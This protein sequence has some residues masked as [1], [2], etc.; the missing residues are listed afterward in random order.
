MS[1]EKSIKRNFLYNTAYQVF[2]MI[3]PFITA[4]YTA[5]VLEADGVGLQSYISSVTSYFTIIAMLGTVTYGQR[6]IARNR[7]DKRGQSRVFW[8]IA[9]VRL[10]A[11][12]I[13]MIPWACLIFTSEQYGVYYVASTITLVA[14]FF[15]ISWFYAGIENFKMVVVRNFFV[16]IAAIVSL[17]LF[18]KDKN[19]VLIY[20]IVL[21]VSTL[22][23]NMSMWVDLHK[24]I[25]WTKITKKGIA[26]HFKETLVY[27]IPT[28]AIS[29]YTVLD[30]AMLGCLTQETYENGYYEQ[31]SKLVNMAKAIVLS[32][33]TVMFTRMS[34]LFKVD[35]EDEI[36]D[37]LHKSIDVI[38]GMSLPMV[39]GLMAIS[40]TFVPWF[41]GAGYDKV[42]TLIYLY[43][44]LVLVIGLSNCLEQQYLTPAG[45]I[46]KSNKVII[47]GAIVNF[48]LNLILIPQYG[49]YG[50]TIAS[51]IAEVLILVLFIK[52]STNQLNFL[53]IFKILVRRFF[54]VVI[55]YVVVY[56]L[57]GVV[58]S[59]FL[60]LV[61]Q[62]LVGIGVYVLLLCIT[63]DSM[64][65]MVKNIV[66]NKMRSKH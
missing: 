3:T 51:V 49:A 36:K 7:D 5:R 38:I 37:K 2:T 54:I 15:D 29:V 18:V 19:D 55:M 59:P 57:N 33:N 50:A 43:M 14:V 31:A 53:N 30:K 12:M 63:K 27:F 8:E 6:E 61:I 1:R 62:V 9:I 17:F 10:I 52:M 47:L 60:N 41:L 56:S 45:F 34:Y 66:F 35:K 25:A 42:V 20:I 32:L 26:Y 65:E 44:P 58:N 16:K 24:Y 48:F 46:R 11:L 21:G 4:P 39:F 64:L 22:V 13:V 28:I 40:K 23:G